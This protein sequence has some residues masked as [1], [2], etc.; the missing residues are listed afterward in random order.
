[1]LGFEFFRQIR[2]R[3]PT[4][5]RSVI[6]YAVDALVLGAFWMVTS[7]WLNVRYPVIQESSEYYR[8]SIEVGVLL[9]ILAL[10]Q[11]LKLRLRWWV[12]ALF[13]LFGVALRL[14]ITAD[15]ISNR[16]LYHD[17]RVPIDLYLVPEFFRLLY[18]TSPGPQ[19]ASY[20]ALLVGFVLFSFA[21]TGAG[22]WLCYRVLGQPR[23][24]RVFG[25][26]LLALGA[27]GVAA[28]T[29][30]PVLYTQGTAKRVN[31]EIIAY[32]KLE[33]ERRKI[34]QQIKGVSERIGVGDRL[35]KLQGN[36]VLF[37]FVES[38]GRT[39]WE[40]PEHEQIL[41]PVFR[42]VDKSLTEAG[43]HVASKFVTSPTFGGFSW[44][45]HETINTGFKVVSHLHSRLLEEENPTSLADYFRDAGY[46]SV[47][48]APAT[49]RPWPGMDDRFGFQ[50]HY[51]AWQFG[52]KGPSFA[53][54]P[55]ADQFVINHIHQKEIARSNQPLFIEY[56][57]ISTHAPWSDIPRYISDWSTVGDGSIYYKVGRD[58]YNVSW[59][60]LEEAA[61]AYSRSIEYE[62]HTL[63]NYFKQFIHDDSLIIVLGDH[64]P[65]QAI[66][67]PDNL[68]WSVP[69]HVISR[70][71]EFIEPFT[72]R[73]FTP[74][75]VPEQPLP[76]V[77]MERFL[78]EFLSDF[79]SE[80]LTVDPGVWGPPS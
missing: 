34:R 25:V 31:K 27:M 74:G 20:T 16:F 3:I 5:L 73:G 28:A 42:E 13:S 71:R 59:S 80:P 7:I 35:D 36:N 39:V 44:F 70:K 22:T 6:G 50:N 53:W 43:F 61:E 49:T 23:A 12:F 63:E 15:S 10:L 57:L 30:G 68:T 72:R 65:N 79:S 51:F 78:E 19:L 9:A 1:M 33:G 14:F 77:G 60:Q 67:G 55:M 17:F 58:K 56:V 37:F 45:A 4:R 52:Y 76:H 64:Q 32:G 62:L 38:Y 2:D 66:T 47:L 54:A 46:R 40:R 69:M 18:D 8:I 24:R 29:G 75:L 21:L 26:G 11:I 41:A 48:V